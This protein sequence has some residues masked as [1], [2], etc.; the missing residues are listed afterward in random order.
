MFARILFQGDRSHLRQTLQHLGHR[1]AETLFPPDHD[2]VG[3]KLVGM[4]QLQANSFLAWLAQQ[5]FNGWWYESTDGPSGET[6]LLLGGSRNQLSMLLSNPHRP[7]SVDEPLSAIKQTLQYQ[8]HAPTHLKLG[9]NLLE[10]NRRTYV[11]GILNVTTDSFSDGGLYLKP[12]L[13]VKHAEKMLEEGADLIDVGGQSSRPGALPVSAAIEHQRVLPV[14][15]DIV[16]QFG[17][18]VSVDTYR[19][20]VAQACLDAGA[21][22]INDISAMRFD[23]QMAPLIAQYQASVVLMHMQGTPKTMQQAPCYQ[24]VIDDVYGFFLQQMQFALQH[25]ISRQQIILDPGFGFGKTVR[26]DFQLLQ[27][28]AAFKSLGQPILVGTSRKS[29]LGH[30]LQREV[31]DR[32]EGTLTSVIHAISQGACLVRVHDVAPV[33]QAVRLANALSQ[34]PDSLAC[35]IL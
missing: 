21:V 15:R 14:V 22:L 18:G 19:S 11:M 8:Q 4:S 27:E 34:P 1:H 28:L 3:F 23:P 20:S 9:D 29:F 26:H 13:A 33:V 17:A 32:L 5:P 35:S 16:K 30:L 6:C 25:G 7:A 12:E 2:Q 24:H 10:V 31:W